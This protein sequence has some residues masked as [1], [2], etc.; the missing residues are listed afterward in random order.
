MDILAFI[1]GLITG[2]KGKVDPSDATATAGDILSPKTAYIA[3]GKAAGT[4]PS[5][6]AQTIT[7]TASDQTI[8]AGKYLAGAQIVEG[9]VCDNLTA[10][11]IKKDVTV[12][13][14]TATDDDSVTIVTGSYEG[15]APTLQNKTVQP[16]TSQQVV[17]ADSGY[18]GLDEVT[19]G[20]VVISDTLI[21]ANIAKD[22]VVEIGVSG[23]PDSMLRITGSHEGGG[24]DADLDDFVKGTLQALVTDA[25]SIRNYAAY[26]NTG[27]TSVSAPE[28]TSVGQYAFQGCSNLAS[29]S[30]PKATSI[31]YYAFYN[32]SNLAS[33]SIPL[34]V[35]L[36]GYCFYQCAKLLFPNNELLAKTVQDYALY[37]AARSTNGFA[38]K[39][40]ASG[41]SAS[42]YAFYGAKVIEVDGDNVTSIGN[43]AFQ[44]AEWL[45]DADFGSAVI[46]TLGQYA[47]QNAGKS[48]ADLT[49]PLLL[50]FHSGTFTS[51]PQYTFGGLKN[52]VVTLP[53]SVTS[54]AGNAFNGIDG[55]LVYITRTASVPTLSA[56]TVFSGAA[57]SWVVIPY[58]N[59]YAATQAANWNSISSMLV[60]YAPAGTFVAGAALPTTDSSSH[61]I[62][63]STD[64]AGEGWVTECPSG[65]PILYAHIGTK[66]GWWVDVDVTGATVTVTGSDSTVYPFTDG[67]ATLPVGITFSIDAAIPSGWDSNITLD[68]VEVQSWPVTGLTAD[69]DY[70][71]SGRAWDPTASH[72]WGATWAPG[73]STKWTRTDDAASYADPVP[74]MPGVSNYGSPFD[75]FD[76]WASMVTSED[77]NAG[78]VVA[79]KKFWYKLEANGTGGLSVKIS[80]AE[81]TGFS[82]CPAC[83][84]RGDGDGERDVVY[85]GRYHCGSSAWKSATGQT[86]KANITRSTARSNI[87]NLGSDIW[88]LDFATQFTIWLLYIVEYADWNSQAVI[89]YGCGNNSS[90]GTM[91]YTDS[92]PYHTGTTQS[93]KTT[94]GLGTQYRNIEGLWDN[95]YDWIGGCYNNSSGLNIILNLGM[96]SDSGNGT[97]IGTPTTGYPSKFAVTSAAG[98]PVF[99]IPSEGSGSGSTGSC[100]YWSFDASGPAVLGGG[101]YSQGQYYGLFSVDGNSASNSYA[102]IGARLLKLP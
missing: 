85:V 48:R 35:T 87:H 23:D 98:L 65:S 88:L 77:A 10:A 86:P 16:T 6:A 71:L 28:T 39:P 49:V 82:V 59:Y 30:F 4:I 60:G 79:I 34:A 90:V 11:N 27:L 96:D 84:D 44:N 22:V 97:S 37:N 50:D 91:G 12:K 99:F 95:V 5:Q 64:P 53:A 63:W 25:T 83:A 29:A 100:D 15:E 40:N 80:D 31:G 94:Y 9:V 3:G 52:T 70:K 24:G 2:G 66:T 92:M 26:Q 36:A 72:T 54:L 51:V 14:G 78:T 102:F 62:Y 21:A 93:S 46:T 81:Q 75:D 33:V 74:Y 32:L 38:W 101:N 73:S 7:P 47:F 67:R 13:I 56:T 8:A 19:V 43:N 58:N 41:A 76:P 20:G 57:D 18:D 45:A 42:Q 55:C 68:G 69:H 89:G 61:D 1:L 17:S